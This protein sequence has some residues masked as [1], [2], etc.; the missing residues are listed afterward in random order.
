MEPVR[1]ETES[2]DKKTSNESAVKK[3]CI[4][5]IVVLCA[6]ILSVWILF[7]LPTIIYHLQQKVNKAV[8]G[9]VGGLP[10]DIFV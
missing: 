5:K 1:K 3:W 7:S 6:V 2:S 9:T 8:G 10:S 4:L